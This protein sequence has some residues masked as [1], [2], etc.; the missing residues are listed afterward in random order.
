METDLFR[1]NKSYFFLMI[2]VYNYTERWRF[3]LIYMCMYNIFRLHK[4]QI[5]IIACILLLV[6]SNYCFYSTGICCYWSDRR[7]SM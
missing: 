2:I 6:G 4:G 5:Y 1:Y 3:T 7:E